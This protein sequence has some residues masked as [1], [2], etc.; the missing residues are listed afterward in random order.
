MYI[1][2]AWIIRSALTTRPRYL[3]R[4][5][6]TFNK[7]YTVKVGSLKIY[8]YIVSN[9]SRETDIKRRDEKWTEEKLIKF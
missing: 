2:F 5:R 9:T 7:S 8:L 1:V 3:C 4:Q 6:K